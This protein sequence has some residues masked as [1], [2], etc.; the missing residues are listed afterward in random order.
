[1]TAS[2][3]A[4]VTS[5]I[6]A[7]QAGESILATGGNAMDA[8]IAVACALPLLEPTGNGL[9]SDAFALVWDGKVV[10]GYNGSGRSPQ[11]WQPAAFAGAPLMPKEG[12]GSVT[13]PGAI[14]AWFRLHESYGRLSFDQC[15][16]PA[17][18]FA[19]EG[20]P[21]GRHTAWA[22]ARSQARFKDFPAFQDHF[23]PAG[24][25]PKEGAV[26]RSPEYAETLAEIVATQG[27]SFY[28]GSLARRICAAGAKH[29]L[30][31]READLA[32][33]HGQ[34]VEPL[35]Q[36]T[37]AYRAAE[38]PPNG[39]G[40]ATL[41]A[42]GILRHTPF[43]SMDPQ[44]PESLHWQIEAMK[45]GLAE[46]ASHVG[47]PEA[48][49]VPPEHLLSDAFLARR[50]ESLRADQAATVFASLPP[51]AGTVNFAVADREGMMVSF[52]QSN[53]WGFGSGIVVPGTGISLQNRG[54]GFSLAPGRAN[55]V[56]PGKRP[57]HTIIPGFAFGADGSAFAFG[58]M[59]GHMQPQGHL[60]MLNRVLF[61]GDHPQAA[62]DAP[63][64][65]VDED[66]Q[67]MF[68]E[69]FDSKLI[70]DLRRRGHWIK[71]SFPSIH[72]GGFQG[73]LRAPTGGASTGT[74]H[75]K[76]GRR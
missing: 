43:F 32:N 19:S 46:T 13:V 4:V 16:A 41:I 65:Q 54:Y 76:D 67:L 36:D 72:F 10:Q 55:T 7:T 35:W 70:E 50:A 45:V 26:F 51:H 20:F 47:E 3:G 73:I 68:E 17:L 2:L 62:S 64:W 14:D 63:R 53:F 40:L 28:R 18:R 39:Q 69:G 34:W 61:A 29:P 24:F 38:I 42:A 58:L 66:F 6:L 15:A 56:G 27:E 57:F 30:A 8:A 25:E 52:I 31:L 48:L 23:F 44:A 5:Q 21:L 71:G 74:D 9:G 59:G 60:Q 12:C 11:S 33:H 22:W 37:P 1:M 75:R 49:R